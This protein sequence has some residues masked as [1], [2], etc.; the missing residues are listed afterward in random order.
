MYLIKKFNEAG[1]LVGTVPT[2]D[3]KD[4]LIARFL[5]KG[6]GI[7]VVEVEPITND[8][9]KSSYPVA[10]GTGDPAARSSIQVETTWGEDNELDRMFWDD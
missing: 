8:L 2:N 10:M 9:P 7:E 6:F 1:Q 4:K 3:P 5:E